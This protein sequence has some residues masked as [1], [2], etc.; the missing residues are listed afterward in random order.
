MWLSPCCDK[1]LR[2]WGV[3]DS[4]NSVYIFFSVRVHFFQRPCTKICTFVRGI[5]T[6]AL[7]SFVAASGT[8]WLLVT[9][10]FWIKNKQFRYCWRY[11]PGDAPQVRQT[12]ESAMITVSTHTGVLNVDLKYITW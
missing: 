6:P 8:K 1:V 11:S 7:Q 12:M 9:D 4:E 5:S 10:S 3:K 2:F